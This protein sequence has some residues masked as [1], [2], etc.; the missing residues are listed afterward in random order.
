MPTH[1]LYTR[2]IRHKG[3][4]TE[5]AREWISC[6]NLEKKTYTTLGPLE[7]NWEAQQSHQYYTYQSTTGEGTVIF[8]PRANRKAK[9]ADP[10]L[11]AGLL[12]TPPLSWTI[13]LELVHGVMAAITLLMNARCPENTLCLWLMQSSHFSRRHRLWKIGRTRL[14]KHSDLFSSKEEKW[15]IPGHPGSWSGCCLTTEWSFCCSMGPAFR[16]PP[17]SWALFRPWS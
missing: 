6:Q 13:R 15:L 2:N 4:I 14:I 7:G 11:G 10:H 8:P 17:V 5:Q 1:S 12:T 9:S 16:N 3:N